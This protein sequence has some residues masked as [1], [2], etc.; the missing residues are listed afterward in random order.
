MSNASTHDPEHTALPSKAE[1]VRSRVRTEL[2]LEILAAA[3]HHLATQGA[4]GLS[5]RAVAR[6]VGMVSSAVY[7]Y[8]PSRDDLLTALIVDA[9]EDLADAIEHGERKAKRAD[10]R[11]RW[12]AAGRALRHWAVGH[13]HEYGLIYGTPIPGYRAPEATIAPVLRATNVMVEILRDGISSGTI[14]SPHGSLGSADRRAIAPIR[15]T[16]PDTPPE[17]LARGF[18]AWVNLIGLVSF[19]LFGHMNNVIDSPSTFFDHELGRLADDLLPG[20]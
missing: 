13:P 11:A 17:M 2:T 1:G 9:Y 7:R 14:A 3:K 15:E 4:S 6:D 8:F 16:F 10:L 5:L 19:E 20:M 12:F 18:G